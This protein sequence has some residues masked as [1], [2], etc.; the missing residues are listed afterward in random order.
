MKCWSGRL[1]NKN[2]F[3]MVDNCEDV[4]NN[5]KKMKKEKPMMSVTAIIQNSSTGQSHWPNRSNRKLSSF[6][7]LS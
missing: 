3:L 6:L 1:A 5:F 2:V 7:S 4:K